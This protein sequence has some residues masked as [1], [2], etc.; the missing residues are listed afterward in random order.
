[1]EKTLLGSYS[2]DITLQQAAADLVF[3]RTIDVRPLITHRFPLE[4]PADAMCLA[5]SP[6]DRSLKVMVQP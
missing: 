6:Q 5:S 4:R 3:S 2:S 1:L